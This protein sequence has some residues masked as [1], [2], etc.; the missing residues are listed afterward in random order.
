MSKI[1][2]VPV[3]YQDPTEDKSEVEFEVIEI[4][5]SAGAN[6]REGEALAMVETDKAT[7]EITAPVSGEIHEVFMETGKKYKYASV[8]CTIEEK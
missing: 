2:K 5:V 1:H 4:L 3:E 8:L 6:V 7:I